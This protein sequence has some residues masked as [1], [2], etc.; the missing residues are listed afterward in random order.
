M[1][2]GAIRV[3]KSAIPHVDRVENRRAAIGGV[4][5]ETL[6]EAKMRG[7]LVLRTRDR[8]VTAEDF[9]QL[10]RE[11]A[12]QVARVRPVPARSD[13]EAGGVRV[14]VVPAASADDEGGSGSRTW[15]RP[16]DARGGGRPPRRAPHRRRPGGCE[17]PRYLGVTV[18]ATLVAASADLSEELQRDAVLALYRYFNPLPAARKAPAGRSAGRCRPARCTACC[19][20][21]RASS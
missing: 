16:R 4:D 21:C 3:L 20:G 9:E 7:P 15:S 8:A 6:E 2:A 1:S 10:A 17:P 19:S 14:L 5:G 11:A 12:P 13:D 18:V